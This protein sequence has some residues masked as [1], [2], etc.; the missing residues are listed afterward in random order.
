MRNSSAPKSGIMSEAG[1]ED[2]FRKERG[3]VQKLLYSEAVSAF[4]GGLWFSMWAVY[5]T[6]VK[7]IPAASMGLAMGL[8]G[9][10][11]LLA[12]VGGGGRPPPP[13]PGGGRPPPAPPTAPV[14]SS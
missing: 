12:A 11:G 2:D 14:R 1:V 3:A 9:G 4:G 8:G 13:A 5:L 7:G 6:A 10:A